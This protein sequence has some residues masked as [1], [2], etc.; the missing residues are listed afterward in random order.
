MGLGIVDS[1]LLYKLYIAA[2]VQITR[3]TGAICEKYINQ[4]QVDF[5]GQN[6]HR[7]IIKE[8]KGQMRGDN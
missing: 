1:Q 2:M 6:N 7:G 8:S 4:Q 5:L 3:S